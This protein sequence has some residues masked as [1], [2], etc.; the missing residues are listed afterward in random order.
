MGPLCPADNQ[1]VSTENSS[2]SAHKPLPPVSSQTDKGTILLF[3]QYVEPCWTPQQHKLALK[4]VIEFGNLFQINGRG[5]VAPEGLNCTLTSSNPHNMRSFCQALRDW[6]PIFLNTDFKLTDGIHTSKLFR[7]LSI[8]KATELVAYGLAGA[9][10]PSLSQFGGTHLNAT[11][12]HQAMK[13]PNTVIVDVRNAYESA[14]GHFAPPEGGAKLLDPKMRNSIE[15]PKWL[16]AESTK[17]ELTGKK[18]LMYCTGGIRCERATA[19]L[20]Q[21]STVSEDLKPKGVYHCQG[22]I[23]RYVKTYPE[24]GFW[25]GKNYLFDKR[26]EQLPGQ[27]DSAAS[28]NPQ[29]QGDVDSKC[30]LCR[31]N[32]T[33]YRGQFKCNRSLCGV[34]VIVCDGCRTIAMEQPENLVCELC[35]EGHRAPKEMPDLKSLKRKAEEMV[36]NE[37]LDEG[38]KRTKTFKEPA[39]LR[40]KKLYSDRLFLRR[41]PLNVTFSKVKE[42]LG[43]RHVSCLEWLK[44]RNTGAYYGSCIVK[45]S[46]FGVIKS[47]DIMQKTHKMGKQTVK[48]SF[49]FEKDSDVEFSRNKFVQLEYPPLGH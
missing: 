49:V 26:M 16:N 18:V 7:S 12:Y 8:R 45:L 17:K 36:K 44:D 13:D 6:N 28:N 24:G 32:W 30:C 40:E 22:G 35:R 3:Y 10:A 47:K 31:T 48:V 5:R 37:D 2:S 41:L 25:K 14:I 43:S 34:P 42:M 15:F 9:K 11:D 23:E 1:K 46:P 19:L 33:V 20:N 4:K 21:I 29:V 27:E 38:K 39:V